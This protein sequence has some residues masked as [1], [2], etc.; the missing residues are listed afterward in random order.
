MDV[1]LGV[2]VGKFFVAGAL[3]AA[4][5]LTLSGCTLYDPETLGRIGRSQRAAL[6]GALPG[7]QCPGAVPG[8]EL[9]KDDP[10]AG[11]MGAMVRECIGGN[12]SG[13]RI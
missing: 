4:M 6:K 13:S 7:G 5:A 3:A 8:A 9:A 1:S 12:G 2:R 10:D 11:V